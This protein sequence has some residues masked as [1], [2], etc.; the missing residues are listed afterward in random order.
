MYLSPL[1]R[2]QFSIF[3]CQHILFN[4][5]QLFHI[6]TN[7]FCVH[8]NA[9]STFKIMNMNWYRLNIFKNEAC[10]RNFVYALSVAMCII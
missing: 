1:K 9:R 6:K 10:T 3:R 7:V 8:L 5:K 4:V 2:F